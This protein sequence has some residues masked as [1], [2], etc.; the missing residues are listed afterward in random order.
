MSSPVPGRDIWNEFISLQDWGPLV[1]EYLRNPDLGPIYCVAPPEVDDRE[2]DAIF[3]G[4]GAAGRFGSAFLRARGGRQLVLDK[5]PFLGGSCPHEACVPHH[6]FSEAARYLDY[7]RLMSNKYWCEDYENVKKRASILEIRD[8]FLKSRGSAH[9]IMNFQSKEQLNM[10]YILNAE[11][12][13]IDKHTVEA[14][15][16]TFKCKNLVL[17]VGAR[18]TPPDVP[19]VHLKGVVNFHSMLDTEWLDFEPNKCVVIGGGKTAIEYGSFFQATGC[20]TTI[21]T[22][23]KLMRTLGLH[24]VDEDMRL[25]VENAMKRR[26]IDI[27]DNMEPVSINGESRVESVTY[28]DMSSAEEFTV[29]CDM[30]FLGTGERP[31]TDGFAH[32]GMD[33]DDK[34]HIIVDHHME[35]S[36]KGVY[37]CGDMIPGP[38]EM[39]K[40]RKSGV[41]A[42]RNIMGEEFE[43]LHDGQYPDFL[44]S[45]YEVVWTGLSEEEARAKYSNVVTIK[46][47][48]DGVDPKHSALPVGDGSMFFALEGMGEAGLLKSVIDADSRKIV[49][50]QFVAFGVRNAFQY[51]DYLLHKM[52]GGFT[53]DQMADVNELFL[54]EGY[55]QLHRLRA[56]GPLRD[57]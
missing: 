26:G 28:R 12:K 32:L 40:A 1:D 16:M 25:W 44:H 17:A 54:N 50:L 14:A 11:A 30:V 21:L 34:G 45:T 24:N 57:L 27:F 19:G 5:W 7:A 20:Q 36:V 15:G 55:P 49:G 23:S 33:L 51:L 39:F 13:V 18:P 53:A 56:G 22:R 6:V 43:F 8:G 52:P 37:A 41:C 48:P 3:I 47:P 10:E 9:G 35:S 29:D 42:A 31:L 4:G 38:R 2:Y 46:L